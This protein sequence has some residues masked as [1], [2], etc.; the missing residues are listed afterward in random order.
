MIKESLGEAQ[1]GKRGILSEAKTV[2]QYDADA[3]EIFR[4]LTGRL[5]NA[6]FWEGTFGTKGID[7]EMR[8]FGRLNDG[9][10][11]IGD[12]VSNLRFFTALGCA[13]SDYHDGSDGA[14][15]C[16]GLESDGIIDGSFRRYGM[17]MQ[18][19]LVDLRAWM[20]RNGI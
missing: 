5:M 14:D 1:Q 3:P 19:S 11:S 20:Q 4:E 7:K 15:V 9:P 18:W 12:V 6:D 10:V 13:L 2:A 8:I 17:S 16:E